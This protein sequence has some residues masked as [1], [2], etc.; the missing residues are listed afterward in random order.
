MIIGLLYDIHKDFKYGFYVSGV[1]ILLSGVLCIPLK[2][3]SYLEHQRVGLLTP[4]NDSSQDEVKKVMLS[5]SGEGTEESA[6][7]LAGGSAESP[8]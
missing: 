2:K 4:S 3:L 8:L 6:S 1:S 7:N 5:A